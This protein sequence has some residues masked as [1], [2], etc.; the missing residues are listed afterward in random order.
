MEQDLNNWKII[1]QIA[2]AF[3][4]VFIVFAILSALI[5]FEINNYEYGSAAPAGFIQVVALGSMLVFLLFAALSFVVA[6][7]ISRSTKENTAKEKQPLDTLE[8]IGEEKQNET[9]DEKQD[10]DII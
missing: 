9:K 1:G 6:W 5:N 3:G 7:V 4:I 10:E 8:Q 2:S